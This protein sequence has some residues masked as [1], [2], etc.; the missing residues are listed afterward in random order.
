M[1]HRMVSNDTSVRF[2]KTHGLRFEKKKGYVAIKLAELRAKSSA[3][4]R[5]SRLFWLKISGPKFLQSKTLFGSNTYPTRPTELIPGGL[6]GTL[7][8]MLLH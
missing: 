7:T 8:W 2:F 1:A 5:Y 6:P 4:I 3:S